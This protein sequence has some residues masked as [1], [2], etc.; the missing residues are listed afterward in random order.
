LIDANY[1]EYGEEGREGDEED[2]LDP[3]D[4]DIDKEQCVSHAHEHAHAVV[5]ERRSIG[6][7]LLQVQS[8]LH[9]T[10]ERIA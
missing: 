6:I 4:I 10:A 7:S 2:E 1:P 8:L 3:D 5:D 9:F